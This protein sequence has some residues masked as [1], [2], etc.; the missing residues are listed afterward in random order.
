M[1]RKALHITAT[2]AAL[3]S[4][5]LLSGC[6]VTAGGK[7]GTV[8][9]VYGTMLLLSL[10]LLAC[11]CIFIEKRNIWFLLLLSAVVVVDAGYLTLALSQTLEEALLANRISYLGSVVLPFS[12]LMIILE[13]CALRRPKWLP[14][15]LTVL[16]VLVFLVAA[17]PGYLDIYYADVSI[18][19]VGGIT[20]LRKVYGPWHAL[21]LVYLVGYFLAMFLVIFHVRRKGALPSPGHVTILMAAVSVN[22]GVWMLE[23]VV[24]TDFE[25][26]CVSYFVS[27]VFLISLYLM[28]QELSRQQPA[29]GAAPEPADA[30]QPELPAAEDPQLRSRCAYLRRHLADLTATERLV[31]DLYVQGLP[32]AQVLEQLNITQNTLKYHNRNLYGKLG[33]SSRKELRQLA[34]LAQD[35]ERTV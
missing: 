9:L 19:T 22:L 35:R 3:L 17:S 14:A 30:A 32:T 13:V 6:G 10:V 8:V 5:V 4:L 31:Y 21:Y 20:V 1:A 25:L 18:A 15:T 28:L 26:L 29:A 7:T 33:V 12:M 34:L 11:Y 23:Q 2:A 27:E 16:C 24:H